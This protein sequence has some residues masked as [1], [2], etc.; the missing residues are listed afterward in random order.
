MH[1]HLMY[2]WF[3]CLLLLSW[4]TGCAR[5]AGVGAADD[6]RASA[7]SRERRDCVSQSCTPPSYS[8][9]RPSPSKAIVL[10]TTLSRKAR[11]WLTRKTV[12]S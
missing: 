2:R 8:R 1:I 3:A 4:A 10:V 9:Q 12:P 5:A 6:V 11:S 7:N